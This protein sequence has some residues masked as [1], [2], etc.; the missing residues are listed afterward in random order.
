MSSGD[1]VKSKK[2]KFKV[3]TKRIKKSAPEKVVIEELQEKYASVSIFIVF[4]S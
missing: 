4:I 1:Q 2:K 3:F